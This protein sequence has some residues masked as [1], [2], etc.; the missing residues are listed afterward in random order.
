MTKQML[1]HHGETGKRT[2]NDDKK[3]MQNTSQSSYISVL[4]AS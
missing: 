4:K 1:M 2:L 3:M